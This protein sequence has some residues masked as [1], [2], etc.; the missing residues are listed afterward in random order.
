M[1]KIGCHLSV[2]KGFEN[3]GREIIKLGG[4][5]FNFFLVIQEEAKQRQL[6]KRI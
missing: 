5:H 3:M 6:M 2:S 1:L 4:I